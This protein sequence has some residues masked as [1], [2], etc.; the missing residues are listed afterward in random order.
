SAA[1]ETDAKKALEEERFKEA[2]EG[3]HKLA[4]ES[5]FAER[6]ARFRI[7]EGLAAYRAGDFREARS[8]YSGAL[9]SKDPK[10]ASSAHFGMGN[11][12][13]QLGWQGLAD[14]PYPTEPSDVPDLERF[15]ILVKERLAQMKDS[16]EEAVGKSA[17]F[18]RMES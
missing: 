12:L 3:Y 16:D 4:E 8:A 10:V 18:V 11:T 13:F 1:S 17:D 14:Q 15:E 7:G 9:L 6:A 5:N 2:R